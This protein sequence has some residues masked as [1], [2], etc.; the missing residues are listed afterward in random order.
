MQR[1]NMSFRT[2]I[3]IG[4]AL[5]MLVPAFVA[6]W[7]Y[8]GALQREAEKFMAD[9]LKARGELATDQFARRLHVLWTIVERLSATMANDK[10][11]DISNL[12]TLLTRLDDRMSWLGFADLG[13][14]VVAASQGMLE[15]EDVSQ[16][17]WFRHGIAGSFAGDVHEAV[18]LAKLLSRGNEPLRF[19]DFSAPVRSATGQVQGA[20]GLHVNWQWVTDQL[21]SMN[22][23]GI[24]LFLVAGEGRVL[25]GPPDLQGKHLTTSGVIAAARGQ[26]LVHP[27]R[28]S[29]GKEYMTA[30]IPTVSYREMPTFGWSVIVRQ[31]ME[32]ALGPTRSLVR[33]FWLI[34]GSGAACSLLLLYLGACWL[35][36]PLQRVTDFA[37]KLASGTIDSAPHEESR[38]R[39]ASLLSAALVRLQTRLGHIRP[40]GAD[41]PV[42]HQQ[43][44]EFHSPRPT[45]RAS[46]SR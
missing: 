17:P 44:F 12:L 25:F 42:G 43:D 32:E 40:V 4:G 1:N 10:P 18:L 11:A 23:R 2:I 21:A 20:V 19:I 38:Y 35:S 27:E 6:G 39:E 36:T 31:D 26:T 15:G 37:T 7:L 41:G 3:M 34:L 46:T 45:P 9:G 14:K 28:W 33:S 8:T 22:G 30:V 29:D 16:R 24:E 13:G 5:L